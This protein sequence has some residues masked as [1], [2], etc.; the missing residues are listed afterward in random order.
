[1]YIRS[2]DKRDPQI[3]RASFYALGL[4]AMFCEPAVYRKVVAAT[5][6]HPLS[7]FQMRRRL[8]G[9]K[10][11][12]IYLSI[13]AAS[14]SSWFLLTQKGGQSQRRLVYAGTER[15]ISRAYWTLWNGDY[16]SE[17][18]QTE[19]QAQRRVDFYCD[20]AVLLRSPYPFS[21]FNVLFTRDQ[22]APF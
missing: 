18:P 2:Q 13:S 7:Q 1:M 20:C 12:S 8:P 19:G 16:P 21:S 17:S 4:K 3:Q 6:C 22:H 11:M 15:N 5:V 14:Q 9:S 10:L